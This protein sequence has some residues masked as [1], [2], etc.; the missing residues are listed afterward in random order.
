MIRGR[1]LPDRGE[2]QGEK[3]RLRSV[4]ELA[5]EKVVAGTVQT[6]AAGLVVIPIGWLVLRPGVDLSVHRP[7]V[8][9]V[10]PLLVATF[11]AA[12]GLALGCTVNQT[13]IGLMFALLVAPMLFLGCPHYPWSMLANFR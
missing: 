8:F 7:L 13:H 10:V 2:R 3:R 12:G 1:L 5:I 4:L 9:V 6:L 11:P